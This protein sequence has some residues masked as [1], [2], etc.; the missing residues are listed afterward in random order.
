M[1]IDRMVTLIQSIIILASISLS[2][3]HSPYWL[4]VTAFMGV[5]MLQSVFTGFCPT[6]YV[7]KKLGMKRGS[8]F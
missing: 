7:L 5:N 8:T 1:N 2:Y 3:Y 4:F 6:A